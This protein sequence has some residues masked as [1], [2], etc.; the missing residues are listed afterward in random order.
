MTKE[1]LPKDIIIPEIN[2]LFPEIEDQSHLLVSCRRADYSA[3]LIARAVEDCNAQLLNLN[4]TTLPSDASDVI[5]SLRINH[6]NPAPVVRSLQRYGYEV[7]NAISTNEE[8]N[9]IMRSRANEI[10]KYLEL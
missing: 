9:E 7:M 3:S 8:D 1:L 6:R 5:V 2:V 4:V 10:L